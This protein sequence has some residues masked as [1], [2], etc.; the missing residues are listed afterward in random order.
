MSGIRLVGTL[1]ALLGA[2]ASVFP[3][4]FGPLTGASNAPVGV[5]ETI[6]QRVRAGMIL[7]LGMGL[8][9]IPSL[10]PWSTSLPT[11]AFYFASGALAA[12]ILGLIV[13]GSVP[14][15]WMLVAVE[16]VIIVAASLW[17]WRSGLSN[18]K[19]Q[20]MSEEQTSLSNKAK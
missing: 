19:S 11:A 3:Q 12:R 18:E 20:S 17:L 5:F 14:K 16:G 1:L 2:I 13:D 15:Q 7:G 6:E 10:R 9:A 8:I 4:W